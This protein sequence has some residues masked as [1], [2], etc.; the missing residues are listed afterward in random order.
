MSS[1]KLF[2]YLFLILM[3]SSLSIDGKIGYDIFVRV[4]NST[5]YTQWGHSH[6]GNV[7]RFNLDAQCKGDGNSSKYINIQGFE[8]ISLKETIHTKEGRLRED[9]SL[10]LISTLNWIDIEE[11]VTEKSERYYV[12][13]NESFPTFLIDKNNVKYKGEG[14]YSNNL[15]INNNDKILTQYIANDFTKS[16]AFAGLYKNAYITADLTPA[17]IHQF[18]G[19]NYTTSFALNSDSN[20]YSGFK[21]DSPQRF[22][23]QSYTGSFRLIKKIIINNKYYKSDED[24]I[25]NNSLSCCPLSG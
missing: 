9:K 19:E 3:T 23:E 6:Y 13:I 25:Y 15:Y 16:T 4:N 14:I 8:G 21:F 12:R 10:S 17:R 2:L 22:M 24:E 5:G 1:K 7:M 20:V 11:Y 18:L